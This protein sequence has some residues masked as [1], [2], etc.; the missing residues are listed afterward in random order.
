MS[1]KTIKIVPTKNSLIV[2]D[3]ILTGRLDEHKDASMIDELIGTSAGNKY[4][5]LWRSAVELAKKKHAWLHHQ[6]PTPQH[7][8][9]AW[10]TISIRRTPSLYR[11]TLISLVYMTFVTRAHTIQNAHKYKLIL[12]GQDEEGVCE[13]LGDKRNMALFQLAEADAELLW[14]LNPKY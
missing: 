3:L 2:A 6:T 8:T 14:E 5:L 10:R 7:W 9:V 1:K 11:R 4:A 13:W 12:V